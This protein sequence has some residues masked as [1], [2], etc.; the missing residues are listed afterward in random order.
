MTKEYEALGQEI[1]Y[2]LLLLVHTKQVCDMYRDCY[3]Y[4]PSEMLIG[5]RVRSRV[6]YVDLTIMTSVARPAEVW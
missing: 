1:E 6:K 2:H 5:G 3:W 4:D